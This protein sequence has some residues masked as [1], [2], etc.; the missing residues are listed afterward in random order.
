MKI[1]VT[2]AAGFIGFYLANML[3]KK[4]YSVVGIDN[5][6]NHNYSDLKI[7]RL[8][9]SGIEDGKIKTGEKLISQ[10]HP[11]YSFIKLDIRDMS[12][13]SD[14]FKEE[15]FDYVCH[16]A[17][18][19]GIRNS[20]KQPHSYVESNING[21]LNILE[22][23]REF[24]V[25]DLCFASSSSIYGLNN[26]VPFST[27]DKTDSPVSI[28]AATKKAD[29]LMAHT[30]SHLY[31]IRCT[32]MRFFTVYGPW[33]RPDMA[34]FSFVKDIFDGREIDVY[35]NGQLKRDFTY[36]DDVIIVIEKVI[37]SSLEKNNK[38]DREESIDGS[39]SVPFKVYNIG[40]SSPVLLQ[41]FIEII[42]DILDKK[43]RKNYL[44]MQAGDVLVT[45]ADI[46]E[47]TKDFAYLPSTTVREGMRKFIIWYRD[48]YN[49]H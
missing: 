36:I 16:L 34:Y 38:L 13:M 24:H 46:E 35:N 10:K 18:L 7:A 26:S 40:N 32:A 8:K 33:G 37:Y 1:L 31:G 49:I 29:E 43:A 42:E 20:I 47:T 6:N 28:Y 3:A 19:A 14:L 2:G 21:F 44:S 48:F 17:A 30:Y 27:A 45:W 22:A 41:N 23:S 4:G 12:S 11:G 5:L 9:E 15:S 25:K 39:G